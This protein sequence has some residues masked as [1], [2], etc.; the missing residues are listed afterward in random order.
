M[1]TLLK[2]QSRAVIGATNHGRRCIK[3]DR[4]VEMVNFNKDLAGDRV[5]APGN[6]AHIAQIIVPPH[7][8][9]APNIAAERTHLDGSAGAA[10]QAHEVRLYLTGELVAVE[11]LELTDRAGC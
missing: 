7:E 10:Q 5:T 6:H 11:I 2:H 4:A 3:R 9:T 1:E 8:H